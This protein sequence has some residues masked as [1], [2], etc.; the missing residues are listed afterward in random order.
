MTKVGRQIVAIWLGVAMT[1]AA[2]DDR[3]DATPD[4]AV[5]DTGMS[6][7]AAGDTAAGDSAQQPDSKLPPGPCPATLPASAGTC[8]PEGLVCQYGNDPRRSCRPSAACT[9][10]KW[11]ITTPKCVNPPPATCPA[12]LADAAGKKCTPKD[13]YC[14][15][16]GDLVC[17]CTNCVSNP[18]PHCAGDFIW[19]CDVPN[20]VT[21]CP[22]GKPNLGTSCTEESKECKY[23]CGTD[24]KRICK[25]KVWTAAGGSPCP[26]SS[27]RAKREIKY[28]SEGQAAAIARRT[29]GV[30]LATYRYKNPVNGSGPQLGFILEDVGRD[31]SGDPAEGQVNLYGY[32]SMLLATVQAQQRS[33]D[34]LKRE[35]RALRREMKHRG[36]SKP[37]R[38]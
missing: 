16:P 13:S 38:E 15:F 12:K 22:P 17:H 28:I 35:L 9:G 24:G 8:S 19:H 1:L 34:G 3:D 36:G 32:T 27:R 33:I 25:G 2:C 10:G 11:L 4:S 5:G 29:L 26:V 21:G 37:K 7:S 6:D 31:Y 18:V 23:H 30:K 20:T 14:T